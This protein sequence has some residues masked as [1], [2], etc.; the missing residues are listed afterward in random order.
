MK[1]KKKIVKKGLT[2][3]DLSVLSESILNFVIHHGGEKD[4]R[5][6]CTCECLRLVKVK[7]DKKLAS[8]EFKERYQIKLT[9]AEIY[10]L[11]Y[12]NSIAMMD[13]N[14]E[15]HNASVRLLRSNN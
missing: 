11:Q 10:A 14:A 6:A 13:K 5:V 15:A 8:S 2:I 1:L 3:L 7:V 4:L 9:N 12:F